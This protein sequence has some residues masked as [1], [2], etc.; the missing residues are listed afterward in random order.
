MPVQE[1]ASDGSQ[2]YSINDISTYFTLLV[3]IY[4]P[5]VTG[6]SFTTAVLDRILS[7]SLLLLSLLLMIHLL[8]VVVLLFKRTPA[9]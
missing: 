2:H 4:F 6:I 7:S 9:G 1:A 5:S 3:G 8:L